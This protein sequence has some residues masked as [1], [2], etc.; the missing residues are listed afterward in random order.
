[1]ISM[2]SDL[3]YQPQ[4]LKA[5]ESFN[6]RLIH[7]SA[8]LFPITLMIFLRFHH[9]WTVMMYHDDAIPSLETADTKNDALDLTPALPI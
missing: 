7:P 9:P 1:M 2:H 6:F 8:I 4:W 3:L 5:T